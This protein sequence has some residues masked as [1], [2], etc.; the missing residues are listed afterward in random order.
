LNVWPFIMVPPCFNGFYCHHCTG[1][2]SIWLDIHHTSLSMSDSLP[3]CYIALGQCARA[4][5]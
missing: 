5:R 4:N 2:L 3:V 1:G